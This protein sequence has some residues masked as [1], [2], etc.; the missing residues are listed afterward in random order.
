MHLCHDVLLLLC[1]VYVHGITFPA[2]PISP[3]PTHTNTGPQGGSG[4][5][6]GLLPGGGCGL[7]GPSRGGGRWVAT[8]CPAQSSPPAPPL[9]PL[10][11]RPPFGHLPLGRLPLHPLHPRFPRPPGT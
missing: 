9:R 4:A 2:D 1:V 7:Q 6:C 3:S 5:L 11:L 8:P 10:P